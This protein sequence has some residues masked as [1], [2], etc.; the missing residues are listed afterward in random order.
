VLSSSDFHAT[1]WNLPVIRW[2]LDY[3][4]SVQGCCSATCTAALAAKPG[5][6]EPLVFGIHVLLPT[7]ISFIYILVLYLQNS[8]KASQAPSPWGGNGK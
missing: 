8:S 4:T 3:E 1:G 5:N 2:P 6:V 7:Y